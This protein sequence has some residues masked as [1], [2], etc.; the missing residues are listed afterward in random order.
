MRTSSKQNQEKGGYR[1]SRYQYL[2][3]GKITEKQM[4]Y[5]TVNKKTAFIL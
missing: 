1:Y 5:K 3:N 2:R 4:I